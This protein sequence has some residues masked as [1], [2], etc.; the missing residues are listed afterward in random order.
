M[1][2]FLLQ[3]TSFQTE[4]IRLRFGP[5]FPSLCG[6]LAG[7]CLRRVLP[8]T[9]DVGVGTSVDT[10]CTLLNSVRIAASVA[11][12]TVTVGMSL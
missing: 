1:G 2:L 4:T 3:A 5:L 9:I 12:D 10:G 8:S 7:E 11:S 6:E